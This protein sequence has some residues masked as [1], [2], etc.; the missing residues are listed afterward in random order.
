MPR[1]SS[2]RCPSFVLACALAAAA[3][4]GESAPAEPLRAAA[5]LELADYRGRVVYLD[6]WASWCG[7]C[8]ES[9]PWMNQMHARY[10]ESGLAILA[11]SVDVDA[12]DARS[13]LERYPARFETFLDPDG[14]M[15]GEFDLPG[16]PSSFLFG[17]DGRR[18]ASHIGFRSARAANMEREIRSAL[19]VPVR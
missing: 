2:T 13:F 5:S 1:P 19:G 6:F 7:P 9:F 3:L 4:G 17:R 8:R 10:A 18:L 16:M 11:V 15:A 14:E 12:A